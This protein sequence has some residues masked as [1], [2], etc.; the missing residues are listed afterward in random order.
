[1]D[2]RY[3]LSL[4]L[5]RLHWFVLVAG[6]IGGV[7][8]GV[9]LT[10]P[11]A[12]QSQTRLIIEAPQIPADLASPVVRT[13]ANQQMQLFQARLLTRETL[14]D[15]VNRT[16]AI[17]DRQRM[18]PDQVVS[19]MREQTTIR[20]DTPRNGIPVMAIA[21]ES[22]NAQ[23]AAAVVNAYLNIVL[24]E[25]S[26][27]RTGR[28]GDTQ[29]FFQQEVARLSDELDLQSAKILEF[30][31]ANADALPED[32]AFRRNQQSGLQDRLAQ[33]EREISMLAEQR[34]R[35]V[36]IFENTGRIE[37]MRDNRSPEEI[38]LDTLRKQLSEALLV[39]SAASPRVKLLQ[40]RVTQLESI[41]LAERGAAGDTSPSSM[42]DLQ[43]ADIDA[44]SAALQDQKTRIEAQ[45]SGLTA[46]IDRTPA[47][48]ITLDALQRDYSNI[49]N[50]YNTAVARQAVASTGERIEILARGQRITVLEQPSVPSRP[51]K[52][53]R[54]KIALMGI[55]AGIAAGL[56][57]IVL[58]EFLNGTAR[59]PGDIAHRLGVTPLATI[60]YIE[61]SHE[62]RN[63][64]MLRIATSLVILAMI[65]VAIYGVHTFY[66]PLD[67]IA[68]RIMDRLGIRG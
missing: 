22:A 44:R 8:V 1:M 20:I 7:A 63:R 59:R 27:N 28:A 45:L 18:S 32:L 61:N 26:A 10:L 42:L 2:I 36:Q 66:Q 37:G 52:P 31:R 34:A 15:I 6:V 13:P 11:P 16:N 56:A 14:L 65:G 25:D 38:E 12:Y 30:K 17:P 46:S 35:M 43:L 24:Q 67:L 29:D 62:A 40:S 58:L 49:Q 23:T 53:E 3:Y 19:E 47:N 5:R 48:A 41:V 51:N 54:G 39:Y 21:F 33:T 9:A 50:Q 60:P 4:F 55:G 57:L 68:E 64:R